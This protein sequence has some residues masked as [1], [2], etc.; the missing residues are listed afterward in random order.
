[1]STEISI[2]A[3]QGLINT[4]E[5]TIAGAQSQI[6]VLN[7]VLSILKDGYKSDTD[8]IKSGID[9]GVALIQS[10]YENQI[11]TLQTSNT[12][13]DAQITDLQNQITALQA[14]IANA[15]IQEGEATSDQAN[16]TTPT[17]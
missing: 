15:Q 3:V 11:T 1:M 6:E 14:Q 7:I 16:Q 13:K 4:Q 9:S 8:A 5:N 10:N 2:T 17:T 12:S